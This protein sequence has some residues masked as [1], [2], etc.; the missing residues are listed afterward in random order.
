M[1]IIKATDF[2]KIQQNELTLEEL[3]QKDRQEENY[4]QTQWQIKEK[5]VEAD[6]AAAVT[7]QEEFRLTV[8]KLQLTQDSLHAAEK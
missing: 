2:A 1:A 8:R 5:L 6:R 7:L 3:K 4:R